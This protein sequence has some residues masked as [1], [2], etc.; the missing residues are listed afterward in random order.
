MS[1]THSTTYAKAVLEYDPEHEAALLDAITKAIVT[2]FAVVTD[3][4][5]VVLRTGEA[6]EA[7]LTALACVLALSPAVARSPTAIRKT[8]D[9]FGKCLRR[10][11]A[12]AERDPDLKDFVVRRSFRGND[13]GGHA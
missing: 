12:T 7:L 13:S 8:I 4:N 10:K 2:E 5:A 9:T 6:A 1:D 11:V 3:C